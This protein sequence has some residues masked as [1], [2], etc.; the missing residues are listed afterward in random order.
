MTHINRRRFLVGAA[1]TTLAL[2]TGCASRDRSTAVPEPTATQ[3]PTA[4]GLGPGKIVV[5][6][7]DQLYITPTAVAEP[8]AT[9]APTAESLAPSEIVVTPNDEFYITYFSEPNPGVDID[10]WRLEIDGLVDNPLSLNY[11]Q[12]RALPAVEE[13]RTVE[14]IGNPVGGNQIGNAIWQG[15]YREEQLN[16]AGGQ[17]TAGRAQFAAA[18]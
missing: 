7:N 10:S 14:C 12:V 5:T 1:G 3:A 16:Q 18:D 9:P 2:I 13:M 17:E 11:D 8:T 15:F 6:P 4:E